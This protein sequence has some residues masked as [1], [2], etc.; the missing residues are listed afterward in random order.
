MLDK[1]RGGLKSVFD[2]QSIGNDNPVCPYC[3]F[4][5]EKM[6]AKKKKCPNCG[7]FILVRTRPSNQKKILVTAEQAEQ[8]EEQWS[9]ISGTHDEYNANR[10]EHEKTKTKL[11]KRYGKEPNENDIQ[12]DIYNRQ[13]LKYARGLKW[14]LYRNTTLKMAEILRKES[15]PDRAL[16]LYLEVCYLDL[17]G[18][19]NCSSTDPKILKDFPPFDPKL[20]FTAPGIV[21]RIEILSKK[22]NISINTMKT[23]FI[24]HNREVEKSLKPPLSAKKAW[25]KIESEF[26]KT[27]KTL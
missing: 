9:I 17:N 11:A 16:E 20:A 3:N 6:P 1:I 25:G 18:P 14:G 19:R 21:K 4:K 5:L 2:K 10:K 24:E 7:E 22:N 26:Q 23:I 15:K 27:N 12:W 13:R 8:V